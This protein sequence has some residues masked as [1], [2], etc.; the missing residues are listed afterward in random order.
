MPAA[1]ARGGKSKGKG[2]GKGIARGRGRPAPSPQRSRSPISDADK[3]S[4]ADDRCRRCGRHGGV[5]WIACDL[6]DSWF[7]VEYAS[8]DFPLEVMKEQE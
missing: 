6:C 8:L 3:D 7:H 5:D 4:D 1:P 2:R